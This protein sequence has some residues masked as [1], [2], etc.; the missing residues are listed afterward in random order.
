MKNKLSTR[1]VAVITVVLF[2][3]ANISLGWAKSDEQ[4]TRERKLYQGLAWGLGAAALRGAYVGQKNKDL[5]LTGVNKIKFWG[6]FGSN[7]GATARGL[8]SGLGTTVRG[9]GSGL[10]ATAKGISHVLTRPTTI[11]TIGGAAVGYLATMGK[12]RKTK[13]AAIA[14]GA[15]V[16]GTIGFM[17]GGQIKLKKKNA[18]L[19]KDLAVSHNDASRFA[20]T[21][22]DFRTENKDLK[23][24]IKGNQ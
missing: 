17:K 20:K 14:A 19:K 3:F 16:G 9:L 12:D 22:L 10:G 6:N 2:L 8:R 1:V 13:T 15:V 18:A 24:G 23:T 7:V 11:G 4:R 5:G 21:A